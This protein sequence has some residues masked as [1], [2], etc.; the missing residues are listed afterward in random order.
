M[1]PRAGLVTEYM[2]LA[3]ERKYDGRKGVLKS[4]QTYPPAFGD[5]LAKLTEKYILGAKF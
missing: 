3:G 1:P 4:S 5:A 2:S